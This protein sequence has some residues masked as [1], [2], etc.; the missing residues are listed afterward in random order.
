MIPSFLFCVVNDINTSSYEDRSCCIK[1]DWEKRITW[2]SAKNI[3]NFWTHLGRG[4]TYR[5][6]CSNYFTWFDL[7]INTTVRTNSDCGSESWAS[8]RRTCV[9]TRTN[10]YFIRYT[11]RISINQSKALKW[12]EKSEK[13]KED[14]FFHKRILAHSVRKSI[15]CIFSYFSMINT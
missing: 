2:L 5:C 3:S 6:D 1:Y 9:D 10:I 8:I 13:R 4:V 15:N 7:C 14:Y 11:I 12:K